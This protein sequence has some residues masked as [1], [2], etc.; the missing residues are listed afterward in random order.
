MKYLKSIF[1]IFAFVLVLSSTGCQRYEKKLTDAE[2]FENEFT[3]VYEQQNIIRKDT[4]LQSLQNEY[5]KA[6][7]LS[8]IGN[9]ELLLENYELSDAEKQNSLLNYFGRALLYM[10]ISLFPAER[11]KFLSQHIKNTLLYETAAIFMQLKI[12]EIFLAKSLMLPAGDANRQFQSR[13]ISYADDRKIEYNA[14]RINDLDAAK[15]MPKLDYPLN[16]IPPFKNSEELYLAQS[17]NSTVAD[18]ARNLYKE[19]NKQYS[20]NLPLLLI[21]MLYKSPAVLSQLYYNDNTLQK[22]FCIL[23][24]EL[25]RIYQSEQLFNAMQN[26][27]SL[28][29]DMQQAISDSRNTAV[30]MLDAAF[31]S[32]VAYQLAYLKMLTSVGQSPFYPVFTDNEKAE[33][34]SA[35]RQKTL[36]L[37]FNDILKSIR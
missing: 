26:T 33:Q 23:M 34:I 28:R 31:K 29:S 7:T 18:T 30:E 3:A 36:R 10:Q 8:N 17:Y 2:L 15:N 35:S 21:K 14:L 19:L 37:L 6:L 24:T 5:S 20:E 13:L 9:L 1:F 16:D 11:D 4:L 12:T 25:V 32:E 27:F 22:D